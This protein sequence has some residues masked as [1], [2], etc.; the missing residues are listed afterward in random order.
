MVANPGRADFFALPANRPF[1]YPRVAPLQ[2][3]ATLVSLGD[4]VMLVVSWKSNLQPI[5]ANS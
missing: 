2:D 5:V 4:R 1:G 3:T